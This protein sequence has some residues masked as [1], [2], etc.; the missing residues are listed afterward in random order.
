MGNPT[1]TTDYPTFAGTTGK[2]DMLQEL[3]ANKGS[4]GRLQG[5]IM[6]ISNTDL[7]AC[8]DKS[9]LYDPTNMFTSAVA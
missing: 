1:S 6:R 5:I 7:N 3:W 8:T 4:P 2:R 9:T